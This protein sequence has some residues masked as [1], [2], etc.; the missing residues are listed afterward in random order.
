MA[1]PEEARRWRAA[2]AKRYDDLISRHPEAFADHAAEF[3]LAAGGDPKKALALAQ[4]NLRNR[5]T[6]RAYELVLQAALAARD[7]SVACDAA[8]HTDALP[9]QWPSLRTLTSR[10]LATC[11]QPHAQ[12]LDTDRGDDAPPGVRVTTRT[13]RAADRTN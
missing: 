4:T 6:P 13:G 1:R 2:A 7:M 9:Y 10:A 3:W 5:R 8:V 11:G 12:V